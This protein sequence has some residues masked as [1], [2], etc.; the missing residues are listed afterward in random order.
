M[1]HMTQTHGDMGHMTQIRVFIS[2]CL[3]L[4]F[5]YLTMAMDGNAKLDHTINANI[6]FV[7]YFYKH[8]WRPIH[9]VYTLGPRAVVQYNHK[10]RRECYF[11]FSSVLG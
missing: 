8:M 3:K 4:L 2:V 6:P 10:P 7:K 9:T 5:L 1:G 11:V